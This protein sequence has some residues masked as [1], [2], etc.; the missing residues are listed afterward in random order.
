MTS[1]SIVVTIITAV[2]ALVFAGCAGVSSTP[3]SVSPTLGSA[4]AVQP[5]PTT[6]VVTAPP[7]AK[8]TTKPPRAP[9]SA[10]IQHPTSAPAGVLPTAA[11]ASTSVFPPAVKPAESATFSR[12]TPFVPLDLPALLNASDAAHLPALDLILGLEWQGE[13]RAYPIS[14]MTYHHIV[15]D[16]VAGRPLLI[17]F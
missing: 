8:A 11:P 1:G 7:V 17:T 6:L 5:S 12:R 16:N 3:S 10:E 15:N 9:A 4:A 14:M 2:V 13:A